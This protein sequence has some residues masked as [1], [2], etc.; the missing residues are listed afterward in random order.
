MGDHHGDVFPQ[1]LLVVNQ[2][3]H[4][5][6]V[7]PLALCNELFPLGALPGEAFLFLGIGLTGGVV[8]TDSALQTAFKG[9][10]Y[11]VLVDL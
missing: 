10:G 5:L 3:R 8:P 2:L 4:D 1:L 11:A 7:H 6:P 9:I